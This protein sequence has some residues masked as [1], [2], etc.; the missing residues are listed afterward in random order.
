M[1]HP[2]FS[3]PL[4]NQQ[5]LQPLRALPPTHPD[6]R[7]S[8]FPT[9]L[10]TSYSPKVAYLVSHT[11]L[12]HDIS[13]LT[14]LPSFF[15]PLST[16]PFNIMSA[17]DFNEVFDNEGHYDL[18]QWTCSTCFKT[19]SFA[20]PP[21]YNPDNCSCADLGRFT[22]GTTQA[23]QPSASPG[24]GFRYEHNDAAYYPPESYASSTA[25]ISN[26][27]GIERELPDL[28][29]GNNYLPLGPE[30]GH[31]EPQH[32]RSASIHSDMSYQMRRFLVDQ[33]DNQPRQ[34][35]SPPTKANFLPQDVWI[36][37]QTK[38]PKKGG[39]RSKPSYQSF[40]TS[41]SSEEFGFV[42]GADAMAH[43][44]EWVE[45]RIRLGDGY[46]YE[47]TLSGMTD[48]LNGS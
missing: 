33:R 25:S 41:S 18:D 24:Q 29:V 40:G 20:R 43:V 16:R 42:V 9:L 31:N 22:N 47:M 3:I 2:A 7:Q 6:R 17:P 26:P 14:Y 21:V 10:R 34:D 36:Q 30:L 27:E 19:V 48:E 46:G 37:S 39:K 5:P 23:P 8:A 15:W 28:R 12:A 38:K 44:G 4:S 32:R 13:P 11:A 35:V 45:E 1:C